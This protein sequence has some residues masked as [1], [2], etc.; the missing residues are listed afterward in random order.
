[1][2]SAMDPSTLSKLGFKLMAGPNGQQFYVG[3]TA[4]GDPSWVAV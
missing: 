2:S 4:Q 3:P 1:M